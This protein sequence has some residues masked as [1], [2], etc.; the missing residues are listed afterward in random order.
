MIENKENIVASIR[1]PFIP[2]IH[3]QFLKE[4]LLKMLDNSQ[5]Q[6]SINDNHLGN[7]SQAS[8]QEIYNNRHI[9]IPTQNQYQKQNF[10]QKLLQ[11]LSDQSIFTLASIKYKLLQSQ[12]QPILPPQ[13][14]PIPSISLLPNNKTH[15]QQDQFEMINEIKENKTSFYKGIK[16]L[17]TIE[18]NQKCSCVLILSETTWKLILDQSKRVSIQLKF[19]Y[20]QTENDFKYDSTDY[21]LSINDYYFENHENEKKEKSHSPFKQLSIQNPIDITDFISDYNGLCFSHPGASGILI[22]ELI[23]I[24]PTI[25]SNLIKRI[26]YKQK[27]HFNN[28]ITTKKIVKKS[29]TIATKNYI[30]L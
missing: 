11:L 16:R 8:I 18:Y 2:P 23:Q 4:K 30:N 15:L 6:Q 12:S 19:Y 1:E 13:S 25:Q 3:L 10:N 7:F 29:K 27:I 17:F 5:N 24:Q 20:N 9:A 14:Q 26:N 22:I 21:D 28:M